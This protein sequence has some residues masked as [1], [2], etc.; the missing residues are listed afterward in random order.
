M[1][2]DGNKTESGEKAARTKKL[3]KIRKMLRKDMAECPK[4]M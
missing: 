2:G 1:D 4:H 3:K